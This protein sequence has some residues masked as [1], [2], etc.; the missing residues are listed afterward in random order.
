MLNWVDELEQAEPGSGG[1]GGSG[2]G[3]SGKAAGAL[4]N[5]WT[6]F[7]DGPAEV[8]LAIGRRVI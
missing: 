6:F 7:Y 4:R 5:R 1:G 8:P 3:G 2:K